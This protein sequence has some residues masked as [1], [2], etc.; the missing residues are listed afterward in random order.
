[1]PG[2]TATVAHLQSVPHPHRY[3]ASALAPLGVVVVDA[4]ETRRK[5]H[6]SAKIEVSDFIVFI[7][8]DCL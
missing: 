5:E 1:L 6:A 8:R 3:S 7:C 4:Q 2:F